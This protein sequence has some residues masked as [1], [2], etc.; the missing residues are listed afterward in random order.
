MIPLV[1]DI[2]QATCAAYGLPM[3]EMVSDRRSRAVAYP[4]QVAMYLARYQT[5]KSLPAI[6]RMFGD[7]DHS[8][9]IHAIRGVE[10][11]IKEDPALARKV[12]LIAANAIRRAMRRE[13]QRTAA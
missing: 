6:G 8:T 9:V 3:I 1:A 7:R 10:A 13:L 4:R 11:R 2:Q 12:T 5:A